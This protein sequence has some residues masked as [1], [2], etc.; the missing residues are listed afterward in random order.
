[1][2]VKLMTQNTPPP[3][4]AKPLSLEEINSIINNLDDIV[5]NFKNF[6]ELIKYLIEIDR[7]EGWF[8]DPTGVSEELNELLDSSEKWHSINEDTQLHGGSIIRQIK[9]GEQFL[10]KFVEGSQSDGFIELLKVNELGENGEIIILG[11]PETIIINAELLIKEKFEILDTALSTEHEW[12]KTLKEAIIRLET[13]LGIEK[14]R[15]IKKM[16]KDEF[17]VNYFLL[18]QYIRNQYGLWRGNKFLIEDV[19]KTTSHPD[20]ISEII[21]G[22]FFKYVKTK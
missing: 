2:N 1:M 21:I 20:D 16:S 3:F 18:G 19:S 14:V 13:E 22:E 10:Y 9:K 7:K 11:E 12:P 5:Y 4:F 6:D 8:T 15:E 17:D